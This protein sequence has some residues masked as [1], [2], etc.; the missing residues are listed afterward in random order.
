MRLQDYIG[1]ADALIDAAF[2]SPKLHF[3]ASGI[4]VAISAVHDTIFDAAKRGFADNIE[5]ALTKALEMHELENGDYSTIPVGTQERYDYESAVD[6]LVENV[7]EPWNMYLSADWLGVNTIDTRLW[8]T[9]DEDRQAI[10]KLANSASKEVYKQ[11]TADK[12]PMQVMASLGILKENLETRFAK[13]VS[14]KEQ[15]TND[16]DYFNEGFQQVIA[17]VKKYLGNNFDRTSVYQDLSMILN[18]SD[19]I[20]VKSALS[21]LGIADLDKQFIKA[22]SANFTLDGVKDIS[23]HIVTLINEHKEPSSRAKIRAK[24]AIKAAEKA[25]AELNGLPESTFATLKFCGVKDITMAEALG[26]S[27]STYVNYLN[28]KTR[29]VPDKNQYALLRAEFVNRAN[30]L[31]AGLAYLDGTDEIQQVA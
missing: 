11:F 6:S 3:N 8:L 2:S 28:G 30:K 24:R 18:E 23:A 16:P 5:A 22:V 13:H 21:R 27:R 26:V 29:L 17:K 14:K 1:E 12:T 25:D 7:L 15:E 4:E 31:L 20:L 10:T 19:D 9:T